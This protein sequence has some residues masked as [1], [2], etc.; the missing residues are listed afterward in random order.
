MPLDINSIKP[1]T[2][3]MHS[4]LWENDNINLPLTLY[5]AIEIP[6]SP[7]NSG[8][9]YVDQ[10]SETSL[11]IEWILLKDNNGRQI[12]NWA[13]LNGKQFML[14]YEDE[15]AEGS[16]YLGTEHCQF[17]T[18][19]RFTGLQGTTFDLDLDITPNFNIDTI[20][21]PENGL[22][23]LKTKVEYQG[24]LLYPPD[25]LPSFINVRDPLTI[26]QS[27]IDLDVYDKQFVDYAN[28]HVRWRQLK[29]RK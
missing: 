2:G 13:E 1:K 22:I 21:L 23:H 29:P 5:Y 11:T 10:P 25:I 4:H 17:N 14:T 3:T 6:L 28:Q 12:K 9:D 20:N 7:F 16:I 24:L 26:A 19:I 15:T 8:H 27:F 18:N